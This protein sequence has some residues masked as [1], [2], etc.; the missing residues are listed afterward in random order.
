MNEVT[1]TRSA[2]LELREEHQSMGEAYSFL[3]EKRTLLA[4]EIIAELREYEVGLQ[5]FYERLHNA[6]ESLREAIRRHGLEG[7]LCYPTSSLQE[8]DCKVSQRTLLGVGLQE[9]KVQIE[10][11][12]K[13]DDLHSQEGEQCRSHFQRLL[14]QC[15]QLAALHGNL[16][17]LY[18]DYLQTERR[19]RALEDVL[20]PEIQE[21]LAAIDAQLEAL[22]LEEAVR[23]RWPKGPSFSSVKG[24]AERRDTR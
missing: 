8:V 2:Y 17:R 4:A 10:D 24:G 1:P 22:E 16:L 23:V 6:M 19:A 18:E 7:L 14:A 5:G 21:S 15:L 11:V 20:L 13:P 3:D 9:A 12:H